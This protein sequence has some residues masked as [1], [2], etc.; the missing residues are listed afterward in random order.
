LATTHSVVAACVL[1]AL[2]GGAA[3]V[4]EVAVVTTVQRALP[5]DLT[6]VAI[7]LMNTVVA[8]AFLAGFVI[9]PLLVAT[10]GVRGTLVVTGAGLGLAAAVFRL[11]IRPLESGDSLPNAMRPGHESPRSADDG[12]IM[13]GTDTSDLVLTIGKAPG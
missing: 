3:V 2:D 5:T 6:A 13:T 4:L 7:G 11:G 12:G 1:L 8:A 10:A 9:A